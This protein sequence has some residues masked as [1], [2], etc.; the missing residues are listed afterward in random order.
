MQPPPP[1][2]SRRDLID[3]KS[4]IIRKLGPERSHR[5]FSYLNRLLGH[6]LC[7]SEFDKFCWLTLGPENIPLHNRF[8]RL[9]L[10]N[11]YQSKIPPPA[12]IHGEGDL[13]KPGKA[14]EEKSS[15]PSGDDGFRP[16]P[17]LC[18]G[19]SSIQWIR[20]HPPPL[21]PDG[22]TG[23]IP[24]Q[25]PAPPGEATLQQVGRVEL[26]KKKQRVQEKSPYGRASSVHSKSTVKV[27]VE[28]GEE[29]EQTGRARFN[30][31]PI[32]PPLG[33]SFSPLAVGGVRR[34]TNHG[35]FSGELCHTEALRERMERI[36]GTQ[37]LGTVTMECADLLNKGLDLYMK[38][39][40]MS[41][42]TLAGSRSEGQFT[43]H[44]F[45][46]SHSGGNHPSGIV[47][48][49]NQMRKPS[50]IGSSEGTRVSLLDFR[51]AMELNPQQLGKDWPFLLERV[52]VRSSEE[53]RTSG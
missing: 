48:L 25:F 34:G 22:K 19:S 20:D 27:V 17:S 44:P 37:H 24:H 8:I 15:P 51:V 26:S 50:S 9:I 32:H 3:L 41:C 12:A 7:K 23:A 2:G 28:D 11:A 36:A 5:Y 13:L 6:R 43:R 39:V 30:V 10:K 29:L 53:Q 42:V 35:D 31:G 49:G 47:W 40:I 4:Q 52:S 38:R 14:L 21:A 1:Q 46:K 18:K 16:P 45:N 33:V